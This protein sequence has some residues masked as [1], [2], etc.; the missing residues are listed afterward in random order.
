PVARNFHQMDPLPE[1]R[2]P[3]CSPGMTAPRRVRAGTEVSSKRWNVSRFMLAGMLALWGAFIFSPL[4]REGRTRRSPKGE[5]GFGE[6][7]CSE[8]HRSDPHPSRLRGSSSP[9]QGEVS[10]KQIVLR[11]MLTGMLALWAAPAWA[12]DPAL[13]ISQY[14]HTAWKVRD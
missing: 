1:H 4:K 14:G 12:L 2:V 3:R 5:V 10:S 13:D 6:G 11:F 8:T 7:S 9:F